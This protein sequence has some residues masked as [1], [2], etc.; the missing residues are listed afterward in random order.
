MI[1][2]LATIRLERALKL[3]KDVIRRN[4]ESQSRLKPLF[5]EKYLD[6]AAT[7]PHEIITLSPS[8]DSR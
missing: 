7:I 6:R 3:K 8:G 5:L 4:S 2:G 1:P